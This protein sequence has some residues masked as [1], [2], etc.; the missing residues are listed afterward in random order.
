MTFLEGLEPGI[1]VDVVG[2]LAPAHHVDHGVELCLRSH[3]NAAC[4]AGPLAE[5]GK[6]QRFV[7]LLPKAGGCVGDVAHSA[8]GMECYVVN[9]IYPYQ[10]D[11]FAHPFHRVGPF[12]P[13]RVVDCGRHHCQSQLPADSLYAGPFGGGLGRSHVCLVGEVGFIEAEHIFCGGVL[14]HCGAHA[15]LAPVRV[16]GHREELDVLI[17]RHLAGSALGGFLR[18]VVIP[19]Y[20]GG[21]LVKLVSGG[22]SPFSQASFERRLGLCSGGDCQSQGGYG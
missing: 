21:E 16:P 17:G 10:I 11:E 6:P 2:F 19:A 13:C 20:A 15:L 18:P 9:G 4:T 12:G 3:I 14:L 7:E 8:V 22:E 5:L 1:A